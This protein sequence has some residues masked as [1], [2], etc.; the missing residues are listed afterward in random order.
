MLVR[1]RIMANRA[2]Q[3]HLQLVCGGVVVDASYVPVV[4]VEEYQQWALY[5]RYTPAAHTLLL[6]IIR[7]LLFS[8]ITPPFSLALFFFF[9]FPISYFFPFPTRRPLYFLFFV[10]NNFL[11][12]VRFL[13]CCFGN[14]Q[15]KSK[16]NTEES[17]NNAILLMLLF[18]I[19]FVY[20]VSVS[21]R[22]CSMTGHQFSCS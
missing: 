19:S 5:K 4:I 15:N 12:G 10:L 22:A 9:L 11:V 2:P 3:S 6:F 7:Y 21:I 13:L 1:F 20:F 18:L 17:Y 14:K 16:P 8:S